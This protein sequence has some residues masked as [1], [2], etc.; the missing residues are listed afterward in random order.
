MIIEQ[1]EKEKRLEPN[2][3]F[4]VVSNGN[5]AQ[6]VLSVKVKNILERESEDMREQVLTRYQIKTIVAKYFM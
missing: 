2:I 5:E 3:L 6:E 1:E 4:E